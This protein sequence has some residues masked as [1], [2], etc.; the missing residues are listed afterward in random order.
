MSD[1]HADITAYLD[2]QEEC[3]WHQDWPEALAALRTV[4]ARHK[5]VDRGAGPQ[6]AGC[7]TH[8][9]FTPHPCPNLLD[10]A[11]AF[12]ADEI[13]RFKDGAS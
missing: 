1:L 9:T 10:L 5:P 12:G 2:H 11:D 7:A 3:G 6:C 13:N 4:V 8:V